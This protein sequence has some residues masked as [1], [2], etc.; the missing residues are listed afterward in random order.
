M[1]SEPLLTDRSFYIVTIQKPI[2]I[3][4][5]EVSQNRGFTIEVNDKW[6]AANRYLSDYKII[7]QIKVCISLNK[8]KKFARHL[9]YLWNY[10]SKN[11]KIHD[12]NSPINYRNGGS[13]FGS[14]LRIS[15]ASFDYRC[16]FM[17]II[18]KK[19]KV[20]FNYDTKFRNAHSNL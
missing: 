1:R 20:F 5:K 15:V 14:S 2:K 18:I 6:L 3:E 19:T 17:Q 13:I 4:Y 16:Q 7:L 9:Q 10:F 12:L 11:S 8:Y